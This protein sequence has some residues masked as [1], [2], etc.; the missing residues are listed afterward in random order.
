MATYFNASPM[1]FW[2]GENH[3]GD[4]KIMKVDPAW[5][6]PM[7]TV[8]VP[9]PAHSVHPTVKVDDPTWVRPMKTITFSDGLQMEVPDESIEHP[10]CDVLDPHW[11]QP[12]INVEQP[13]MSIEPAMI[14]VDNPNSRVPSTAVEIPDELRVAVLE[15]ES[16]GKIIQVNENGLP[17]AVD[18]PPPTTEQLWTS[19]R[20]KR[21]ALLSGMSWRYERHARETRLALTPTDSIE[22][23][24]AYAQALAEVTDQADP[25]AIDWPT[26]I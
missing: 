4:L 14:E 21:D 17:E 6:R 1:G 22:T 5:V 18:P 23:L 2:I 3:G 7:I 11:T 8:S 20:E 12:M 15:A 10:K 24:D 19:V 26:I 16:A 13:D 9:N 25:S